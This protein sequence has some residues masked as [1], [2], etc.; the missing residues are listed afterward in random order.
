M[1]FGDPTLQQVRALPYPLFRKWKLFFLVEPWG[2]PDQ[3]YRTAVLMNHLYNLQVKPSKQKKV[4][5][6]VRDMFKLLLE[7][8]TQVKRQQELDPA[9]I[10]ENILEG[11]RRSG[12]L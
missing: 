1:A 4:S 8:I 11:F 2:F 6:W 5:D 3:E 9:K 10:E 7:R 12:L